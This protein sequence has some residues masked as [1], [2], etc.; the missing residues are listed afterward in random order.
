M[1]IQSFRLSAYASV[2]IV[3]ENEDTSSWRLS[4]SKKPWGKDKVTVNLTIGEWDVLSKALPSLKTTA[5]FLYTEIKKG[6]EHPTLQNIQRKLSD[7][8]VAS[9]CA[10]KA[11]NDEYYII[12][13]I[14]QYEK[15]EKGLKLKKENGITLNYEELHALVKHSSDITTQLGSVVAQYKTITLTSEEDLESAKNLLDDFWNVGSGKCRFLLEKKVEKK[16]YYDMFA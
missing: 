14:R 4:F 2:K 10:F 9:L 12:T 16:E 11:P 8:Y 15:G 7:K 5:E 3:S 1:D 13:S 6:D